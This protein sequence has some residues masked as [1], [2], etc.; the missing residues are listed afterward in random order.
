MLSVS[1]ITLSSDSTLLH[2]ETMVWD[3][4]MDDMFLELEALTGL[5][6]ED[7]DVTDEM[8]AEATRLKSMKARAGPAGAPAQALNDSIPAVIG[9]S[10][11]PPAGHDLAARLCFGMADHCDQASGYQLP[12]VLV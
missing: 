2:T 11:D 10:R 12:L 4:E 6:D 3:K 8:V 1:L 7:H 9:V 5:G